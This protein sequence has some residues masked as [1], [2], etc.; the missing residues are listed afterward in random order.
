MPASAAAPS[1]MLICTSACTCERYCLLQSG[2]VSSTACNP[3]GILNSKIKPCMLVCKGAPEQPGDLGKPSRGGA[4][5]SEGVRSVAS[6]Q[7]PL[8]AVHAN[9]SR[10][11]ANL[12]PWR[13]TGAASRGAATASVASSSEPHAAAAAGAAAAAAAAAAGT[14]AAAAAA[15]SGQ[16]AELAAER[17]ARAARLVTSGSS[18][19]GSPGVA[20]AF[21]PRPAAAAG[22]ERGGRP[23]ARP[24]KPLEV[25]RHLGRHRRCTAVL[26]SA[27]CR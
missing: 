10:P 21:A 9:D 16:D 11:D 7:P 19:S 6:A 3:A 12:R 5:G 13:C 4:A 20:E 26:T 25:S 22:A 18:G 1:W 24:A 15:V 14:G 23:Q 17:A 2:A 8:P 27:L